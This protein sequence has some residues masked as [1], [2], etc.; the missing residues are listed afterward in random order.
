MMGG[1]ETVRGRVIVVSWST[2]VVV[3]LV[4]VVHFTFLVRVVVVV[5]VERG[6]RDVQA[7]LMASAGQVERA[8]GVGF[9]GWLAGVRGARLSTIG[10]GP[11]MGEGRVSERVGRCVGVYI[12][13]D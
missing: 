5:V 1:G 10:L 6:T 9:V 11:L 8:V 2:S 13:G 7:Q 12:P 4:V 3:A